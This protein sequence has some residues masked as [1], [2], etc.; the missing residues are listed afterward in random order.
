M[1]NTSREQG[2]IWKQYPDYSF[3]E[4][5]IFGEVRTKDRTITRSDGKKAI[6]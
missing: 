2:T 4:V 5:S 1:V 3:I 6:Y